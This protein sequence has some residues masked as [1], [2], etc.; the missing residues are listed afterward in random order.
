[1]LVFAPQEFKKHLCFGVVVLIISL[2]AVAGYAWVAWE[3]PRLPGG[4]SAT[5]L[6]YG[7]VGAAIIVFELL[8]AVRKAPKIRGWRLG[9]TRH[10]LLAH[11]WL[12]VLCVPFVILHTGFALGGVL[13]TTLAAVFACVIASGL[14]GLWL[15]N[16]VPA[17]M[18]RLTPAETVHGQIDHVSAQYAASAA[19]LVEATCGPMPHGDQSAQEARTELRAT[20]RNVPRVGAQRTWTQARERQ[21]SLESP[22]PVVANSQAL[23]R[24]FESEIQPYLTEGYRGRPATPLAEEISAKAFFAALRSQLNPLAH[25]AVNTIETWCDHRRQFDVQ[26]KL[27]RRLHGWLLIHLPLSL[28]LLALLIAHVYTGLKYW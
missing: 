6:G 10:W 2:A 18:R 11:I 22:R 26:Q 21:L 16:V 17:E 28:V 12:G 5:G 24:A 27:H 9:K 20:T 8:L 15:Q 25:V 7:I 19:L 3:A 4:S 1:M 23:R 13:T 14:Y